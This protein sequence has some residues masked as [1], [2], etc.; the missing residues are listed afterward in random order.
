MK[1]TERFSHGWTDTRGIFGTLNNDVNPLK[2]QMSRMYGGEF[3]KV[4]VMG[5]VTKVKKADAHEYT[6]E[7][8][9]MPIE[10]CKNMWLVAYGDGPV[11]AVIVMEQEDVMWEIGNRLYWAGELE[12]DLATDTYTCKS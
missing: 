3:E 10:A 4:P 7:A 11:N 8:K 5:I 1:I 12:H 6:T 2:A 9:D